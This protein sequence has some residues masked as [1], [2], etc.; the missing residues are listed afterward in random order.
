MRKFAD[1]SFQITTLD[2]TIDS[3]DFSMV[4]EYKIPAAAAGKSI[5]FSYNAIDADGNKGADLK[6]LIVAADTAIILTETSGHVMYSGKSL[7]HQDAFDLETNTVKWSQLPGVD[8]TALDIKDF[9]TDTTAALAKSWVSP[10]HGKF[11]RA[12]GFDYA[13]ATDVNMI[14]AYTSSTKLE[15]MDNIQINDILITKLGSVGAD[16]YAIIRITG[17]TDASGKE[18]DSY[19]FS[20]KK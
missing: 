8:T 12:N 20:I 13:N 14:N 3:K 2:S 15:I 18:S 17:I 10:A 1:N 11:V 5:I 7:N 19:L 6:R 16:K 4:Y 9:P